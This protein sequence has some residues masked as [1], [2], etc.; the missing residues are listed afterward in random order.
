MNIASLDTSIH[1][2]PN[3]PKKYIFSHATNV[4]ALNSNVLLNP[5][6]R[7]IFILL[8]GGVESNPYAAKNC[9]ADGYIWLSRT[10]VSISESSNCRYA[11]HTEFSLHIHVPASP[12]HLSPI[13]NLYP[14][15]A[16]STVSLFTVG[17]V[18]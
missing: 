9:A 18:K 17:L 4:F 3:G 1:P 7:M 14:N 11:T 5:G 8:E 15:P 6:F 13:S 2:C 10:Y 12:I 16:V